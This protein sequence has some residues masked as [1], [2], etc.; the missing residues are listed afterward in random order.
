LA[1]DFNSEPNEPEIRR[2]VEA[3]RFAAKLDGP[4]TISSY[5][6]RAVIDHIFVP[7]DWQLLE[8]RVIQTGLSDHLPVVSTYRVPFVAESRPYVR[9]EN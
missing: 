2:I 1:G 8:H 6:P 4:F 3:E 5:H 7:K 9:R